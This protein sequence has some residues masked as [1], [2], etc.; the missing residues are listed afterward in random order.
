VIAFINGTIKLT[1]KS[2]NNMSK[3]HLT[4]SILHIE[5]IAEI[6][7]E[8]FR[9]SLKL[10]RS[11]VLNFETCKRHIYIASSDKIDQIQLPDVQNIPD[12]SRIEK[13]INGDAYLLLLRWSVGLLHVAKSRFA[14]GD[15]RKRWTEMRIFEES[16]HI[17]Y[18]IDGDEHQ[19]TPIATRIT[20]A[21]RACQNCTNS[22]QKGDLPSYKHIA[23]LGS[24]YRENAVKEQLK[25]ANQYLG[26]YKPKSDQILPSYKT[27]AEQVQKTEFF[28]FAR[29]IK[30]VYEKR[31]LEQILAKIEVEN[32]G[33]AR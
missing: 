9:G 28:S 20:F 4:L 15:I 7:N 33:L 18:L 30:S 29:V 31:G 17:R 27:H 22:W 14:K 12:C 10:W 6:T 2:I 11:D 25:L 5:N 8:D 21:E 32:A 1:L 3:K 23:C 16:R 26:R 24:E 13:L 19:D